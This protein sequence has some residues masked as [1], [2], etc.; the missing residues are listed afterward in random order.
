M[1]LVFRPLPYRKVKKR[2][3]DLGFQP[4]RPKGSHVFFENPDGR[5]TVVPNHPGEDIGRGMIRK[6]CKDI[7]IDLDNF[8]SEV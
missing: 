4:I 7:D 2:L 3:I 8:Y 1:N 6:I 5:T